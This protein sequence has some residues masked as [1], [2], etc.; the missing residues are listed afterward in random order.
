MDPYYYVFRVGHKFPTIKH[1]T[2]T[3]A[4]KEAERLSNQHPGETFEILQCQAVT[5]TVLAKTFWMDGIAPPC[6][7][8]ESIE[9][10][11]ITQRAKARITTE[12]PNLPN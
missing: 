9:K 6:S 7:I 8:E 10:N 4:A 5:R 12:N 1:H 2:L 3:S 11:S